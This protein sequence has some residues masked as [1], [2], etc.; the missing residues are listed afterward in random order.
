[1]TLRSYLIRAEMIALHEGDASYLV[2]P[3]RGAQ[4]YPDC[5]QIEV[6]G[7]GSVELPEGVSFPGAYDYSDPGV[8]HNVRPSPSLSHRP[9]SPNSHSNRSIAPPRQRKPPHPPP[10]VQQSTSSPAQLSGPARG[11]RPQPCLSARLL[12]LRRTS[13]GARGL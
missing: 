9:H 8:V 5:V 13:R 12:A 6:T 3:T 11:P 10:P 1:L 7:D 4:F 2:N